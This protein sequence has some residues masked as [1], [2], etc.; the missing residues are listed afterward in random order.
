[1][2]RGRPST[3]SVTSPRGQI[4]HGLAV[5]RQ[6]EESSLTRFDGSAAG[7]GLR[8]LPAPASGGRGRATSAGTEA[9]GEPGEHERN[10]T[11][12]NGSVR[13][14]ACAGTPGLR[15]HAF[16][17]GAISTQPVVPRL[18]VPLVPSVN[19][20]QGEGVCACTISRTARGWSSLPRRRLDGH[21]RCRRAGRGRRRALE[22]L[23]TEARF[24][25]LPAESRRA[26]GAQDCLLA[27][28]DRGRR[29]AA[30]GLGQRSGSG[31]ALRR[32]TVL[33]RAAD[34]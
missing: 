10:D 12:A 21:H 19:L 4:G 29:A 5:L 15:P 31:P 11:T 32:L 27:Y 6:R 8:G 22:Q 30:L 17:C 16:A 3:L 2:S 9:T 26:R 18:F 1:M 20:I 33:A 14:D 13:S 34:A 7:F 28:H 23:V 25:D 24:F